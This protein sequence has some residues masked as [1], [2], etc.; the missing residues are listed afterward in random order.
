MRSVCAN[1]KCDKTGSADNPESH[2]NSMEEGS[3]TG[4]VHSEGKE[5]SN[6]IVPSVMAGEE[7][8]ADKYADVPENKI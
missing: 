8:F 1:S 6:A 5:E 2:V 7:V 4:K 3:A